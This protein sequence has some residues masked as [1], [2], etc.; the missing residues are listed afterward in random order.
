VKKAKRKNSNRVYVRKTSEVLAAAEKAF[1]KAGFGGVTVDDIAELAGVSKRTVYSN[2]A[3]KEALFAAVIKTRCAEVVPAPVTD[4]QVAG[5]PEFELTKLAAN[6]LHALYTPEQVALYQ[7]VVAESRQFPELGRMMYQG[8]I[9]RSQE[10]FDSYLR[11]QVALGRM[12]FPNLD[13]AAA[14]L[15][16]LLKINLHMPMLLSQPVQITRSI[17]N[18]IAAACVQLFLYGAATPGNKHKNPAGKVRAVSHRAVNQKP[19]A[20]RESV[21]KEEETARPAP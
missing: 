8:P 10:V 20:A 16:A 1:I 12:R 21:A 19:A 14:Q 5:D 6:F 15:V 18:E 3:N 17:I 9:L 4:E 2:F 13:I 7:T 11:Q